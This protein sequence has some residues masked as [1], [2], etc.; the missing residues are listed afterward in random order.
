MGRTYRGRSKT[1]I[2]NGPSD[3][4]TCGKFFFFFT[5]DCWAYPLQCASLVVHEVEPPT[6]DTR[7]VLAGC[8][9]RAGWAP[10]SGG[11]SSGMDSWEQTLRGRSCSRW[12][13]LYPPGR[14]TDK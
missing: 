14:A 3:E 11:G 12:W 13:G 5:A 7:W 4:E 8:W 9:L 1:F 10:P 6:M 2:S